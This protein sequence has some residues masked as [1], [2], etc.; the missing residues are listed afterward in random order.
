VILAQDADVWNA[1]ASTGVMLTASTVLDESTPLQLDTLSWF[2]R[3]V[4]R[5]TPADLS[6]WVFRTGYNAIDITTGSHMEV[7]VR[8][9]TSGAPL[10]V[11]GVKGKGRFTYADLALG[12]EWMSIHPGAFKILANILS[13]RP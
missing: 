4:N 3:G 1:E 11:S 13:Y 6:G 2:S 5:V 9:A 8:V 7:P 10:V 12:P